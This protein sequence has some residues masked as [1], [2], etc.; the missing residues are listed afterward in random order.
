MWNYIIGYI[1]ESEVAARWLGV[2]EVGWETAAQSLWVKKGSFFLDFNI[3]KGKL[4]A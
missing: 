1:S 4:D 2:S 3:R